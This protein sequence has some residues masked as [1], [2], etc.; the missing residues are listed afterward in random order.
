LCGEGAAH[1]CSACHASGRSFAARPDARC[2]EGNPPDR[3]EEKPKDICERSSEGWE[4]G[5][6]CGPAPY[7]NLG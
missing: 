4:C 5:K 1:S 3:E 6:G 2:G 7:N